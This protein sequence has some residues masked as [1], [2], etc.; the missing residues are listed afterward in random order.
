MLVNGRWDLTGRLKVL[1]N[2]GIR[3]AYCYGLYNESVNTSDYIASNEG[4]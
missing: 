2:Y 4:N 3:P 1:T